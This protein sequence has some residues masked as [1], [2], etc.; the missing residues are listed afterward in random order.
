RS[1]KMDFASR[2]DYASATTM[3]LGEAELQRLTQSERDLEGRLASAQ[4]VLRDATTARQALQLDTVLNKW[5]I[6]AAEDRVRSGE[7]V[8]RK[9]EQGLAAVRQERDGIENGLEAAQ[10]RARRLDES[11]LMALMICE[12]VD[13]LKAFERASDRI[14]A[15]LEGA[16]GQATSTAA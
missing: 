15:A 5:A 4:G 3:R 16:H 1:S 6:R 12:I 2:N 14:A 9:V 8:V 13:A 11:A 7:G 10:D